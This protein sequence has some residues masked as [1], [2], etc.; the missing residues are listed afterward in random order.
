LVR[1][2][3]K[4]A[5]GF[6]LISLSESSL[7]KGLRGPVRRENSLVASLPVEGDIRP[8]AQILSVLSILRRLAQFSVLEKK[9]AIYFDGAAPRQT[10]RRLRL[11]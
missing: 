1:L 2:R 11:G 9:M 5:V 3:H 6:A 10:A 4:K 8:F 7:F